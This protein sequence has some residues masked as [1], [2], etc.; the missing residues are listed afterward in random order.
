MPSLLLA[1]LAIR[2][3][4]DQEFVL[5]RQQSLLYQGLTGQA[6]TLV[7]ERINEVEQEFVRYA[8]KAL[9]NAIGSGGLQGFNQQLKALFPLAQT[10]F[11]V[12][13]VGQVLSPGAQD[14]EESLLFRELNDDFLSNRTVT[15]VYANTFKKQAAHAPD[16]RSSISKS[17][18][19]SVYPQQQASPFQQ[20]Q[21]AIAA[22]NTASVV[23]LETSF[24]EL[25]SGAR[26]GT[27]GRFTGDRLQV[28]MWHK[29]AGT[30]VIVGAQLAT[31]RLA[32]ILQPV[33]ELE[34][35][36]GD[37]ICLALLN[38]KAQPVALSRPGFVTQWKRPFA[39]SEVG[40]PFP[41]W[42]CAVY[43]V[44]PEKLARSAR[45]AQLMLGLLVLILLAAIAAGGWL[46]FTDLRRQ[47]HLAAQKTDFVSNVSHELKTPL[48]SI[49]MFTEL[50]QE[51]RVADPA[52][53]MS[54]IGIIGA[55]TSR[56]T[57]LI[58]N[59]L[60]FSRME[61]GDKQYR[62]RCC[63]LREI[64]RETCATYA[65]ALLKAGF[66]FEWILPALPVLVEGDS[67]ALTQVLVN[68]ISNAEKYSA[69]RKDV[70]V[71]LHSEKGQAVVEV[72]DRGIG[73]PPGY[74]EKI[75]EQFYRAH[76]SLASGIQGCGLGLTLARQIAQAH[77]GEIFYEPRK[78]GG[79]CFTF[80]MP[81]AGK[82]E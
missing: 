1:W 51:G 41:L 49:R 59:V 73:V 70:L 38:D 14:G 75:F 40:E 9:T 82:Q 31:D 79:S 36:V 22:N 20:Q 32:A 69:E 4:K 66:Q 77:A 21:V 58:N 63:D 10:G 33:V 53:Q 55:E 62:M 39:A 57:R 42:E 8:E 48:T 65:P 74:S 76:D 71:R 29:P 24:V 13:P 78:D 3:L 60:D 18:Q 23:A 7:Q 2:S 35:S 17:Q 68:L 5:E 56:L 37:D 15:E 28:I 46:I 47:V 12:T 61:R 25:I 16:N 50:L 27:A 45:T 52:K 30:S 26:T 44:A 81:T 80:Q 11:A 64:V 19:R 6:A 67:D 72:L 54:Y 34:S 43:L